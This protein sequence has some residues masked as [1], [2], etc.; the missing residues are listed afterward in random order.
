MVLRAISLGDR[1]GPTG[2]TR[3]LVGGCEELTETWH[4]TLDDAMGQATFEFNVE[5][6]EWQIVAEAP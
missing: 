1:H 4:Q 5:P 3:H 2:N 6:H